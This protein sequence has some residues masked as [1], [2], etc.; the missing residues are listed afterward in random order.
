M[1][2]AKSISLFNGRYVKGR[3]LVLEKPISFFGDIDYSGKII[4]RELKYFNESVAKRIL[5]IP[6]GRGSTVS[7][8][9]IYSLA[10]RNLAPSAILSLYP[11]TI[12][13]VGCVISNI[14]Y[15]YEI[16]RALLNHEYTNKIFE[17]KFTRNK[18][19]IREIS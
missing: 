10:K 5:V 12:V 3:L 4:N 7:S 13:L 14:P 1:W 19:I 8:Y 16:P 15:A 2:R 17:I 6:H 9:I 18:A 11:D